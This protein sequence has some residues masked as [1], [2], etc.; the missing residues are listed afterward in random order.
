[1]LKYIYIAICLMF[2][3]IKTTRGITINEINHEIK[4]HGATWKA[5]T[6]PIWE[7]RNQKHFFISGII[8]NSSDNSNEFTKEENA[9]TIFPQISKEDTEFPNTI[10]W[11]NVDGKNYITPVKDQG[12][13]GSCTSFAVVAALE[14]QIGI[15]NQFPNLDIDLAEQY[16]WSCGGG[17]CNR[18]WALSDAVNNLKALGTTDEACF[19]YIS[20]TTTSKQMCSEACVNSNDRIVKAKSS[21]FVFAAGAADVARIITELQKG[22]VITQ[23]NVYEDFLAYESGIYRHVTGKYAGGHAVTIVGYNLSEKYW[24][25]K[26]SWSPDWGESGFFKIA[27]D[28]DYSALGT[29]AYSLQ[30][31]P[32]SGMTSISTPSEKSILSGTIDL[33]IATTYPNVQGIV[34]K[35]NNTTSYIVDI[36]NMIVTVD[37]TVLQDGVYTAVLETYI[38][39]ETT[40]Q[41]VVKKSFAEQFYILNSVPTF[42][43]TINNPKEG[44]ELFERVSIIALISSTPIPAEEITIKLKVPA[45]QNSEGRIK[46]ITTKYHAPRMLIDWNTEKYPDGNYEIWV[47]AKIKDFSSESKHVFFS[48]KNSN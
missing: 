46:E 16:L 19:P 44:Q 43:L 39:D 35:L 18:G 38:N 6:N 31:E 41:T 12:G 37:T 15:T 47:E 24:I 34:L 7:K 4:S 22:P 13:C 5:Q 8:E 28:D 27:M 26:N 17:L 36:N 1:M 45:T 11:T 23:M 20:G 42:N 33:K 3:L 21:R 30:V 10:D 25:V 48:V 9:F 2:F 29:R 40:N 32:Y 14:G